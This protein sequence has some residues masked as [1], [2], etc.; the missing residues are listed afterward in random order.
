MEK[1]IDAAKNAL[2]VKKK[3]AA[4]KKGD[5]VSFLKE[6]FALKEQ[7]LFLKDCGGVLNLMR[8]D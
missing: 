6:Y 1:A 4:S 3:E 8:S 5:R 2:E 7:L